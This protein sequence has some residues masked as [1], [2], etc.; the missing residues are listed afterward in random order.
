MDIETYATLA[1]YLRGRPRGR[2]GVCG[3]CDRCGIWRA[4]LH[5]DHII[6]RAQGGSN[7]P[8]NIQRLCANCHQ[9]KTIEDCRGKKRRTHTIRDPEKWKERSQKISVALTGR[10]TGPQSPEHIAAR[11]AGIKR[12][13]E[14]TTPEER[15]RGPLSE[16]HKLKISK[17]MRGN[18]HVA[19]KRWSWSRVEKASGV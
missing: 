10:K 13:A 3:P 8:S 1:D 19:G 6:P 12:W 4:S 15:S 14:R 17:A 5:R 7:E 2:Y 18:T 16:E 9:D 11:A